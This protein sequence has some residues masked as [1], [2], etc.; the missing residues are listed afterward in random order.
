MIIPKYGKK[1]I[2]KLQDTV[3]E[4]ILG[5]WICNEDLDKEVK[6][7]TAGEGCWL[8]DI[9]GRKILD[10]FSSLIT[11]AVGHGR[12]EIGDGCCFNSGRIYNLIGGDDVCSLVAVEG[13][14]LKI[15]KRC[16]ISNAAMVASVGIELGEDVFIG[17]GV[18]I[19]DT[20][21]H[22]LDSRQRIEYRNE[23]TRRKPGSVGDG[24]FIG[25]HSIILKGVSIGKR[26]V[27]GAGS[28]V[29]KNVGDD[30]IWAGAPARLIRK[31]NP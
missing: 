19:Y 18:K 12:I 15:G 6:I 30:E 20:D 24:A 10:T 14:S 22:P 16:Q 28:V 27:I 26:A 21:F 4:K 29:T 11:T 13:G 7:F 17:G 31:V 3:H 23:H 9:H 1:E 5:S 8:Y 25:A 2:K